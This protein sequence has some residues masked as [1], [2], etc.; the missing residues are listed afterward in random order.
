MI[1]F[2]CG[3]MIPIQ[4]TNSPNVVTIPCPSR[5]ECLRFYD[6]EKLPVALHYSLNT[7]SCKSFI[8]KN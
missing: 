4:V 8:G 1:D 6:E 7:K 3:G 2:K 5:D